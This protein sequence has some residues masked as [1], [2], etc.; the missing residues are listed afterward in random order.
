MVMI[1]KTVTVIMVLMI[2]SL[3][4]SSAPPGETL[5]SHRY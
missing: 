3:N 5:Y 2:E 1:N 4:L